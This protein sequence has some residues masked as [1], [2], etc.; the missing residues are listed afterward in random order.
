MASPHAPPRRRAPLLR[1]RRLLVALGACALAA[2]ACDIPTDVPILDTRWVVPAE[3]TRFGVGELL[4]GDVT[5]T[6]DSSAF[7]VNFD[8]VTYSESLATLCPACAIADGTTVPKPPFIGTFSSAIDFPPEVS[9]VTVLD[10]SVELQIYNGLNF[11][12]L[13]P[14]PNSSGAVGSMTIT[15]TDDADGDVLGTLTIDG[16][17]TAMAPG[18]TLNT[19]LPLS[20]ATIDGSLKATTTVDSPL[21][22]DVTIDSSLEVSVTA[23]PVNI[24]VADVTVDVAN[25]SVD[26]DP[27]A[28]D[29]Q[30]V[31]KDLAN[32]VQTGTFLVD[33][34]NPFGISATFQLSITG[35][36]FAPIQKSAAIGPAPT[37]SV[38]IDLTPEEIQRFLGEPDVVLNGSGVVDS[39]APAVTVMPGQELV[40]SAKLDVTIRL[41][42]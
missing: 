2:A 31:D 7:L 23:S 27:V 39:S 22:D 13:R 16:A 42:D 4:P 28:L 14:A 12:P 24:R 37:S 25:R 29:V 26:L 20:G 8:P 18:S 3:D 6:A 35:T 36:T 1:R 15:I 34:T 9:S 32:H 33:V 41:G 17:T 38:E 10:G 5:I 11:D 40:L 30:D 21:G 19:A